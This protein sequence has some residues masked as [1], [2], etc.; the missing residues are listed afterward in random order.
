MN[1]YDLCRAMYTFRMGTCIVLKPHLGITQMYHS[2]TLQ[3]IL[4]DYQSSLIEDPQFLVSELSSLNIQK[5]T[6][7]LRLL[8]TGRK[9]QVSHGWDCLCHLGFLFI[10]H[11]T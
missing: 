5:F 8:F 2:F 3:S 10:M 1:D 6:T 4:R 11:I 9:E 7:M